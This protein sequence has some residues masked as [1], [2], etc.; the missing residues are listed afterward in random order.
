VIG[1]LNTRTPTDKWK[2]HA[3]DQLDIVSNPVSGDAAGRV[4]QILMELYSTIL[5]G[6]RANLAK[7]YGPWPQH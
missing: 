5:F 6:T 2:K 4:K 1:W 7:N 3:R